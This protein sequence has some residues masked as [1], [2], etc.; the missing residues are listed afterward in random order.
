MDSM[1][2]YAR[3]A[4]MADD[5][6]AGVADASDPE[7]LFE[8]YLWSEGHTPCD[9]VECIRDTKLGL[10]TLPDSHAGD[11]TD[12]EDF[13]RVRQS[14]S[15]RDLTSEQIYDLDRAG[16]PI[17]KFGKMGD[18][19]K[20]EV[21][22]LNAN[23]FNKDVPHKLAKYCDAHLFAMYANARYAR[24]EREEALRGLVTRPKQTT[25]IK[26]EEQEEEFDQVTDDEDEELVQSPVKTP[27]MPT[28]SPTRKQKSGMQ[29]GCSRR[30][31][32]SSQEC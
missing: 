1:G 27:P 21:R 26:T 24:E 13:N 4:R 14:E 16:V 10:N 29:T 7:A 32:D 9:L 5:V 17:E 11:G 2:Y 30:L 25:I 28:L 12:H 18:F 3:F 8:K 22:C 23:V 20:G 31:F 6:L 15:Y 19:I